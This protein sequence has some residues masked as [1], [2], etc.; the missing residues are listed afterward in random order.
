VVLCCLTPDRRHKAIAAALHVGNVF[1]AELS[2]SQRLAQRRQMDTQTTFLDCD[3][4]PN[5]FNQFAF[6]HD[7]T[8]LVDERYQY[9]KCP[10]AEPNDFVR[11]F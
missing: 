2:V 11:F 1:M 3:V 10:R 9:V 4:R 6:A 7:L 8:G 5:P